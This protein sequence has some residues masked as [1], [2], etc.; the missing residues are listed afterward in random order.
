M[1][2]AGV[3]TPGLGGVEITTSKPAL[4]AEYSN[5][6]SLDEVPSDP[7]EMLVPPFEQFENSYTIATPTGVEAFSPNY[8]NVVV[9]TKSISTFRLDGNPVAGNKFAAIGA[10]GFSGAQLAVNPGAHTLTAGVTFGA[11]A[12]GYASFNSYG[13][14]AGYTLSPV[15]SV[16][17]L[18]LDKPAYSASTGANI[19]PIATVKDSS[20]TPLANVTVHFVVDAPKAVDTTAVT[21]A[22]GQAT[23]CFTSTTAGSGKLTATAGVEASLLTATATVE[24]GT[25]TAPPPVQQAPAFT[26]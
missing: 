24:F 16:S 19:C 18:T 15:A 14:P 1:L 6:E 23:I 5:G 2:P 25:A 4:V 17:K 11:F 10:S 8:V 13:Y 21:N 3:S 9:P 7:M 26:G 22:S 20:G 12:Y